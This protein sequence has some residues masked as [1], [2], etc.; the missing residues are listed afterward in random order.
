M[1]PTSLLAAVSLTAM[2]ALPELVV[3]PP[4]PEGVSE[5]A[6]M[7]AWSVITSQI[8]AKR[9]KL[10]VKFGLQKEAHD[11]LL[12][13]GRKQA[14]DC[15][16]NT[17]CLTDLG[18]TL[19]ADLLV[20]GS[21]TKKRVALIILDVAK[22]KKL[23]GVKSSKKLAKA[24]HKRRAKAAGR[25]IVKAYLRYLKRAKKKKKAKADKLAKADT[26]KKNTKGG[27]DAAELPDDTKKDAM[28]DKAQPAPDEPTPTGFN[29][30]IRIKADQMVDVVKV[31]VDGTPLPRRADG[32]AIWIGSPGTHAVNATR[33]DG[34]RA[35]SE[36]LVDPQKIIDVKLDFSQPPPPVFTGGFPEDEEEEVDPLKKWWFWAGIGAAVLVGGVTSLA[37]I[38]GDK[39]GPSIAGDFGSISGTY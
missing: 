26:A 7:N 39:G 22:G 3:L 32:S 11:A 21:I 14:W 8:K 20:T 36:V 31:T 35:S 16:A 2:T 23:T 38:G 28:A 9:K 10:K 12:G 25:G 18:G 29:G 33:K 27:G 1:G 37:L 15:G 13:P 6:A 19:G 30:M 34:S 17:R 24:N 4:A 5:K